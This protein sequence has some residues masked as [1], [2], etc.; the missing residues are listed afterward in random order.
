MDVRESLMVLSKAREFSDTGQHAAV[1]DYLAGLPPNE[2]T[3][4]PTLALLYGIAQARI[5]R[6]AEGQR[7]VDAAGKQAQERGDRAVEARA[8]NVQGA[9]ALE[10]GRVDEAAGCFSRALEAARREGDHG[11]V[12]RCSNNLGIVANLRGDHGR[13]I[14]SYTMAMAAFEQAGLSRGI[15]EARHNLGI[16]YRDQG[17]LG[18]A[19]A[20]AEGAVEEADAAGDRALGAQTRAGRAEIR[21]L[22]GEPVVGRREAERALATHREL[23]DVVGEA[24]ALRVLALALQAM[25]ENAEA[26]DTLRQVIERAEAQGRPLLAAQ[27]RRDLAQLLRRLGRAAEAKDLALTARAQFSQL[28]AEAEV[29]K[30]DL[31]I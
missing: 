6:H 24:E 28:G 23:G 5:G 15:S 30:L 20:A 14:G 25:G 7:W 19:L 2:I 11:T 22:A 18:A 27:A 21:V 16:T 1:V 3:R 4:S 13:A 9:I 12:G 17:D 10:A 29:R 8:L 26:E 31:L